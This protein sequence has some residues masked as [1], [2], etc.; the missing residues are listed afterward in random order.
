M[1]GPCSSAGFR[2]GV[3]AWRP[4]PLAREHILSYPMSKRLF[5]L[6]AVSL[7]QTVAGL[8]SWTANHVPR[9]LHHRARPMVS[10]RRDFDDASVPEDTPPVA[11]SSSDEHSLATNE[12]RVIAGIALMG[13]TE[14]MILNAYKFGI[15]SGQTM[16]C[17]G[18]G[19]AC[20]DILNGPWGNVAGLPLT[21]P[22]SLMYAATCLL[23]AIPLRAKSRSLEGLTQRGLLAST[24]AMATFSVYLMGILAFRIGAPCPWCFTS[25]ALSITLA[26][27][28]WTRCDLN[29]ATS[30]LAAAVVSA[31]AL[32][33]ALA[34]TVVDTD[35]ALTDALNYLERSQQSMQTKAMN[36]PPTITERS[37]ARAITLGK[38]L[39]AKKARMYG[40]Y[41]CSHCFEQKQ[42]LGAEA[43]KYI[44][45]IECSKEGAGSQAA[46]CKERAIP[47][48]PTWEI[49][50]VFHPGEK[51]LDE[52]EKLAGL[53][54]F[55]GAQ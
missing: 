25:A 3:A 54:G 28:V 34:Y 39:K 9:C 44:E 45:Y 8:A 48:Y 14:T 4:S 41:W 23:A 40:A 32:T 11:Q 2:R 49:D 1:Y 38:A 35:L 16:L 18:A 47:G 37:S 6:C 43:M 50:G 27:I 7:I 36:A 26:A 15:L 22:G 29:L 19:L 12:R 21:V 31:T 33:C 20:S 10:M 30:K 5:L 13:F 24:A 51:G 52:L 53:A 42:R 46:L 55:E 17:T